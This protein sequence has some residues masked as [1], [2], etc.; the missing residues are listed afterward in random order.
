MFEIIEGPRGS[1]KSYQ[2]AVRIVE[3][4]VSGGVVATNLHMK[5]AELKEEL[6]NRY[7]WEMLDSQLI[8][9]ENE[10]IPEFYKHTPAGTAE[11]RVLII[12]EEAGR[13]FNARDW[14][15]TSRKVLDFIALSR[16]EFNDLI[17]ID[18]SAQNIDKQFRRLCDCYWVTLAMKKLPGFKFWPF[19]NYVA[20]QMYRDGKTT[21]SRRMF[22]AS[23]WVYRIYDSYSRKEI[24]FDRLKLPIARHNGKVKSK[25][26]AGMKI[27]F[28]L[29]VLFLVFNIGSRVWKSYY[30]PKPVVVPAQIQPVNSRPE[31]PVLTPVNFT[32]PAESKKEQPAKS[33][34]YM[35]SGSGRKCA[36]VGS[37]ILRKGHV[38]DGKLL[39]DVKEGSLVWKSNNSIEIES[40]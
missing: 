24:T 3:E 36:I 15:S 17:L 26:G 38:Y 23:R 39:Y 9:L 14:A 16:H 8:E 10:Q 29:V 12:I 25:G 34:G 13:H 20:A 35:I 5:R 30:K 4:I 40:F 27:L 1:Y 7:S 18:Q 28:L 11:C 6:L 33:R 2:A 37:R 22:Y 19:D 31:K 21:A 32:P